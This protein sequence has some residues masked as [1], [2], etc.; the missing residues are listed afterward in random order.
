MIEKFFFK[1]LPIIFGCHCR[2]DRS[3]YFKNKKFPICARCT[4]EL[5]GM[6]CSP[7][8]F[9]FYQ[10]TILLNLILMIPML[11]DGFIQLLT[12]YESNNIKRVLTGLLFGYAL[13]NIFILSI[14]F[15]WKCG[16]NFGRNI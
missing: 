12:H 11:L 7:F 4:G 6:I 13:S 16:Y 10:P 2:A 9:S 1:W 14:I 8:L 5:I 15:T 3:F